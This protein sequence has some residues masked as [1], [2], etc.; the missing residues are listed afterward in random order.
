MRVRSGQCEAPE[1]LQLRMRHDNLHEL[2]GITAPTIIRKHKDIH[3]IGERRKIRYHPGKGHLRIS[4]IAAKAQRVLNGPLNG[5]TGDAAC[6]SRFLD[7][8]TV[9]ERDVQLVT[10]CAD[11]EF[12]HAGIMPRC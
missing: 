10:I 5:S 4:K 3:E 8:E 7:Q 1:S 9:N 11:S 12:I 6:P 2:L